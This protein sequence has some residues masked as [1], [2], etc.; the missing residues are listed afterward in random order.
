MTILEIIESETGQAVQEDTPIESLALDS[1][2][3]LD[4]LLA[5]GIQDSALGSIQTVG[6]IVRLAS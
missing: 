1:L 3:F 2:E 4:L 5:V 6:D